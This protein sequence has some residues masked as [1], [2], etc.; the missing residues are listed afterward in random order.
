MSLVREGGCLV[1]HHRPPQVYWCCLTASPPRLPACLPPSYSGIG[2]RLQQIVDWFGEDF[3]G[4]IGAWAAVGVCH[5]GGGIGVEVERLNSLIGALEVVVMS[6]WC[7]SLVDRPPAI[8]HHSAEPVCNCSWVPMARQQHVHSLIDWLPAH[9]SGRMS[10]CQELRGHPEQQ[11]QGAA[12]RE[13]DIKGEG[14]VVAWEEKFLHAG[15]A[16]MAHV[17]RR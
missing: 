15:P 7:G 17:H 10:P 3:D 5:G 16:Q 13:Q 8:D 14:A 6:Q 1:S 11:R 12:G 9:S 2:T 4:L